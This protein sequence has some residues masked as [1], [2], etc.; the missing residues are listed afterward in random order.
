[1]VVGKD[2]EEIWTDEHGRVKVKFF[3]DREHEAKEDASCWVRVS[4]PW[5]GKNFGFQFLPRV[6]QEVLVEFVNGDPDRPI[7]TG[8]MYNA[9]NKH[10]HQLPAEKTR[11]TIKSSSSKGGEG[12][13]QITLEDKKGK[14]QIF[15]RAEKDLHVWV[16]NESRYLS[17][18][19]THVIVQQ[20]LLEQ[21]DR[22][23]Q[24]FVVGESYQEIDKDYHTWIKGNEFRTIDKNLDLTV[25]GN[26]ETKIDGTE[27]IEV[28]K[29]LS[30]KGD[31]IVI[32][33]KSNITLKV[34]SSTIAIDSSSITI[35]TGTLEIK[36]TDTKIEAKANIEM[37]AT[38]NIKAEATANAEIKG[39]AG[40]KLES[41]A[42]AEMKSPATTV[43]GDGML[44][45]KGGVTMI[46]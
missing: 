11:S 34:G 37:K 46:N 6:G 22:D 27:S 5:A 1:M 26:V 38:A 35:E 17:Q 9:E 25:G 44:T 10:P 8:R 42:A 32:E 3:W 7:V 12:Y 30:I 15:V 16:N 19:D 41:T 28:A 23:H 24:R 31:V 18:K 4:Q 2:G 13:N 20:D 33:G 40:L 39:T 45:L 29:K 14:E 43:K 21:V 36:T